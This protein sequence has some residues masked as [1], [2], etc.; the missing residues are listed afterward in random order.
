[1]I[2]A[3]KKPFEENISIVKDV[4][5]YAHRYDAVVEA[6][7]GKL[8]GKEDDLVVDEKDAMY[9][10]PDDAAEFVDKTNVDSLAI[11][12][13]TAHGLYKGEP[14]LDFE[15]LKEIRSK[16]SI[17]L[18]LHGASDV[19]DELVKEA[20]SLGICKV[21]VATDLKIPFADAVKKFFNENSKESD[22]RKYM[23]PGKEAMKEIVKHKIE[24]CGS[25]NRY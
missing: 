14:K 25:A 6:E 4:V 3:S 21:N 20:I 12:I 11:A 7:L 24:V 13:G 19:P 23:T 1:M 18:V 16:V 15:R 9:T 17:P 2:D 22:P 8:G 10:N 5:E